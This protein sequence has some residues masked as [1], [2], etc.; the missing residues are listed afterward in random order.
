MD[1]SVKLA[2]LP[3]DCKFP[4]RLADRL[5]YDPDRGELHFR[6]FM[7]K[8]TYDELSALSEDADYHRALERLFVLTSAEVAP[9]PRSALPL[10]AIA[11]TIGGLAIAAGALW[12]TTRHAWS[13]KPPAADPTV[14]VTPNS[15]R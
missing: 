15:S 1:H 9:A 11:A 13:N 7:T 2:H 4:E 10:T 5:R 6:G 14:V 3:A 12:L 8:C